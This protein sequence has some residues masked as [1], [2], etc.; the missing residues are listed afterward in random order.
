MM[1]WLSLKPLW[2]SLKN[3][4]LRDPGC[5]E[6]IKLCVWDSNIEYWL[7]FRMNSL[8]FYTPGQNN[9][10]V[11]SVLSVW[12]FSSGSLDSTVTRWLA[13]SPCSKTAVD[14]NLELDGWSLSVLEFACTLLVLQFQSQNTQLTWRV[15]RFEC[16]REWL[17]YLLP[18]LD[19]SYWADCKAIQYQNSQ[20]QPRS[21]R[22]GLNPP[23]KILKPPQ[24]VSS[25]CSRRHDY[26]MRYEYGCV[27]RQIHFHPS[28]VD[29]T[30]CQGHH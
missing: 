9:R 18:H 14:L 3:P 23:L 22:D 17:S 25:N 29:P 10:S 13:Q 21:I 2:N 1:T 30:V 11:F 26:D 12:C 15:Q 7:R 5:H 24:G 8:C 6:N 4:S 16:K 27:M 20:M 19:T 28:Y